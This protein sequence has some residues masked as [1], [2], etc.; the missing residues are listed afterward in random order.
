[1]KI[2]GRE[3]IFNR[4]LKV[5]FLTA[6]SEVV[7]TVEFNP[8]KK[9]EL[10]AHIDVDILGLPQ[11]V[12]TNSPGFSASILFYNPPKEL[13]AHIALQT[14][15]I[16]DFVK[17]VPDGD[18]LDVKD[19][20]TWKLPFPIVDVV[21]TNI[22]YGLMRHKNTSKSNADV[23]DETLKN[24][25]S[26]RS[27]VR[28]S[29]GY[30]DQRTETEYYSHVFTGWLNGSAFWH[31]GTDNLLQVNCHD[32]D[33]S[34]IE[35]GTILTSIDPLTRESLERL[36]TQ[37]WEEKRKGKATFDATAKNYITYF[38]PEGVWDGKLQKRPY[39][40]EKI[41]EFD[42][43]YVKSRQQVRKGLKNGETFNKSWEYPELKT[44]LT[45]TPQQ[46]PMSPSFK[47]FYTA[48]A[49]LREMLS[50]MCSAT[51]L[52]KKNGN[53]MNIGW[54]VIHENVSKSTYIF[55]PISEDPKMVRA[56]SATHKIW[57]YQNLL[58]APSVDG[59]G[60]LTIKMM[61]RPE[62][63]TQD[64]IALMLSENLG[65]DEGLVPVA[66][67]DTAIHYG[68]NRIVGTMATSANLRTT[69]TVQLSEAASTAALRKRTADAQYGGYMFNYG[70]MI[71]QFEHKLSTHNSDWSTEV[72]TV[73]MYGGTK[74]Q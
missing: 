51:F 2:N 4:I 12:K 73:P 25:Y 43:W 21:Q 45:S 72:K 70:F 14:K 58:E 53:T 3:Y 41:P 47:E 64:S 7:Y 35:P 11:P 50:D 42:V 36:Q 24:F 63:Q 10:C 67:F 66:S 29:A 69:P 28:V 55:F 19:S 30:Y 60:R 26:Q 65:A 32:I 6:S 74:V 54:D 20:T 59:A 31:K 71:Y 1:M 52:A 62:I 57:N 5:E 56:E 39:G 8:L 37:E 33:L 22:I 23:V 38:A 15:F 68:T 9:R 49:T 13:V 34:Q 46:Q 16:S 48:R 44:L 17:D 40:V 27:Q 18:E 61:F